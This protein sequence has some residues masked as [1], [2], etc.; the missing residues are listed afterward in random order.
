MEDK[1]SRP[2]GRRPFGPAKMK[3]LSFV[4]VERISMYYMHSRKDSK[5]YRSQPIVCILLRR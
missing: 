3:D 5:P 2:Q 4:S 1:Y